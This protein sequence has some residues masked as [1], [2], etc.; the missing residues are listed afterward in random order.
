MQFS[1]ASYSYIGSDNDL[2]SDRQHAMIK[3][4]A[5]YGQLG[6]QEQSYLTTGSDNGLLPDR[7]HAMTETN[8]GIL[9]T[10]SSRT[11]LSEI[12]IQI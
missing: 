10:G 1:N 7:H 12:L 3:T 4:N 8:A 11:N 9:S 5:T 6:P 2:L